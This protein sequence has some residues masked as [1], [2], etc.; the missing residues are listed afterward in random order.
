MTRAKASDRVYVY[1]YNADTREG[2]LSAAA[3]RR[4]G[5]L[6]MLLPEGWNALNIKVWGFVVDSEGR[7]SGSAYV[8]VD[9][10]EDGDAADVAESPDGAFNEADMLCQAIKREP[11]TGCGADAPPEASKK[12]T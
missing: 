4:R 5:H 3:R 8:A 6:E 7:A 2:L 9:V 10:M 1:V 11:L 12:M